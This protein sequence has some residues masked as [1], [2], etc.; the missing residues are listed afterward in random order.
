[1][2]LRVVRGGGVNWNSLWEQPY[3]REDKI[4]E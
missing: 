2:E 4:E 3:R 1:M